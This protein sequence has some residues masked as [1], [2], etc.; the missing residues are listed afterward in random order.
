MD[1]RG[2]RHVK[3]GDRHYLTG[4][5]GGPGR[6]V[7]GCGKVR[8]KANAYLVG[9]IVLPHFRKVLFEYLLIQGRLAHVYHL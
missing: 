2:A 1:E 3:C 8:R 5:T 7:S 4:D 6:V 9:G